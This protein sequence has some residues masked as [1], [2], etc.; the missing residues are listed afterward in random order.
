MVPDALWE[1]DRVRLLV[2]GETV[3]ERKA[4]GPK[5][6]LAGDGFEVRAVMPLWGGS[7][8]R[9][10]LVPEDG[11]SV[12]LEP[13]PG[14][15]AARRARFEREHPRLHASRFVVKGIGRVALAILGIS[16][17]AW[18]IPAIP[19]PEINLPSLD[20][21]SIP[22]P[23]IP[24]PDLP[25][26]TVPGWVKAIAESKQYWLPIVIGIALANAEL[27][28]RRKVG[29]RDPGPGDSARAGEG[30]PRTG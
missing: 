19:W 21:P 7:V 20:L 6:V 22:W 30:P 17:L 29:A 13:E 2:D 8:I 15:R 23:D 4:N 25:S 16:L 12:R 5:T 1:K 3:A 27:K 18:L 24:L 14:T 10:E 28:R 26:I 11:A 9:A